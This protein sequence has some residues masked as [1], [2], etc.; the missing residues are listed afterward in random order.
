MNLLMQ[1][2]EVSDRAFIFDNSSDGQKAAFL[3]EIE[4]SETLKIKSNSY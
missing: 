3:A 2:V 4:Y 1:A